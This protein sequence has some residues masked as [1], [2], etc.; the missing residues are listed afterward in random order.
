MVD[1]LHEEIERQLA[2]SRPDYLARLLPSVSDQCVG[3]HARYFRGALRT[4]IVRQLPTVLW[5]AKRR[6]K[7]LCFRMTIIVLYLNIRVLRLGLTAGQLT[8]S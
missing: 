4:L 3:C 1:E 8:V 5:M 6:A 2:N 7:R